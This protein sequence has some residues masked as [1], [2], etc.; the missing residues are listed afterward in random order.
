M[1]QRDRSMLKRVGI[2]SGL[3]GLALYQYLNYVVSGTESSLDSFFC[4]VE[5]AVELVNDG[6]AYHPLWLADLTELTYLLKITEKT[7]QEGFDIQTLQSNLEE[8]LF[9]TGID[10][11]SRGELD[12][13][14]GAFYPAYYF[15]H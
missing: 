15:R 10:M 2:G 8:C 13:F 7:L 12:P 9:Q 1:L 14:T 5:D 3:S 11:L 4:C 6:S